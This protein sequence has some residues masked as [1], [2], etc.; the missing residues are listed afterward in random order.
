MS[1]ILLSFL[2]TGPSTRSQ[3]PAVGTSKNDPF[4]TLSTQF[5]I[6]SCRRSA[7]PAGVDKIKTLA[8]GCTD[9]AV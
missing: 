6:P 8:T 9:V 3:E 4:K 2:Q 1:A 5:L 7:I